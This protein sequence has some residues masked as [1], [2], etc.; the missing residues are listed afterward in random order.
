MG[1]MTGEI[2]K[3]LCVWEATCFCPYSPPFFFKSP[4]CPTLF[5][6]IWSETGQ[7]EGYYGRCTVC[8][9]RSTSLKTPPHLTAHGPQQG[10]LP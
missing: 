6:P 1:E 2:G 4:I 9:K 5:F 8:S 3:H 10:H 7:N